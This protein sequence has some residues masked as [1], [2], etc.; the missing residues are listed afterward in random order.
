MPV[1]EEVSRVNAPDLAEP[2]E[3]YRWWAVTPRDD[4]LKLGSASFNFVWKRE[5][6]AEPCHISGLHYAYSPRILLPCDGPPCRSNPG[7]F[8]APLKLAHGC[9]IYA[10]KSLSAAVF[11]VGG[12]GV[13][14]KVLLGGKVWPYD[15]GYRAEKAKIVGL[16]LPSIFERYNRY[17]DDHPIATLGL[18]ISLG[19]PVAEV[20]QNYDVPLLDLTSAEHDDMLSAAEGHFIATRLGLAR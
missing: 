15:F 9:G 5:I 12:G 18:S 7:P 16:Y 19:T 17:F 14:G 11:N 10:L 4:L 6:T 20:A 1:R 13:L 2:I 8:G 3:A